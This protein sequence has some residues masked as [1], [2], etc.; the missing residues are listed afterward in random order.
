MCVKI[1]SNKLLIIVLFTFFKNK[2]WMDLDGF[3]R[4]ALQPI[5]TLIFED[6]LIIFRDI[7][8]SRDNSLISRGNWSK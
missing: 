6:N 2:I 4:V 5:M 3:G 7:W 1:I 8:L